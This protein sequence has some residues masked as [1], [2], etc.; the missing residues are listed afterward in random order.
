MNVFQSLTCRATSNEELDDWISAIMSPL[1]EMGDVVGGVEKK[2]KK[3]T[4]RKS[5]G[6]GGGASDAEE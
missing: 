1:E 4:K 6:G 2:K 5:G 3:K